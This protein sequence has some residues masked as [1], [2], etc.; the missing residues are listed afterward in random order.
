MKKLVLILFCLPLS[1][2]GQLSVGNNQTICLSDIATVIG[3]TSIQASTDSYQ[4]TDITFD[5]EAIAGTSITLSDDDMEGP[6]SIGFTFQFYGNNYTDFYVGS[7]GWIGFSSVQNTSLSAVPIPDPEVEERRSRI[8]MEGDVPSP[9]SPP[10]GC[11]FNTRCPI[12]ED[13]CFEE[14][15][16]FKQ[17]SEGHW[18]ACH[19]VQ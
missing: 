15:P 5:P 9:L 4:V 8:I 13:R 2:F 7:N 12:A 10:K 14:D 3:T 18:G 19:L 6:F 16:E 17:I 1:G 11:N